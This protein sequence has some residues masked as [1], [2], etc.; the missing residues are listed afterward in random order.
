MIVLNDSNPELE[1]ILQKIKE[2]DG[3]CPCALVKDKDTKCNCKE[4]REIKQG[5]CHCGAF[6]KI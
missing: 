2:N 6:V 4:F 3:Y 5:V 1:E